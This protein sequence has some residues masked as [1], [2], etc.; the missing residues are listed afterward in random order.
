MGNFF[1]AIHTA[2]RPQ[3]RRA[4]PPAHFYPPAGLGGAD[5]ERV[6]IKL[7]VLAEAVD[8]DAAAGELRVKGRNLTE[9]E[10]VKLG[11]AQPGAALRSARHGPAPAL[12]SLWRLG[13]SRLSSSKSGAAATPA[14]RIPRS[15]LRLVCLTLF[16]NPCPLSVVRCPCVRLAAYHSLDLGL[17]RA[18][19]FEKETWDSVADERLK[20]R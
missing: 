7:C 10:W 12:L 8:F 5:S 13:R 15:I 11:G 6:K 14:T 2:L 1:P 3:H 19:S 18:V 4:S 16:V 17:N 20:A 9:N